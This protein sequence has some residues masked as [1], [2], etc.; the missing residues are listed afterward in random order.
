MAGCQPQ[1]RKF[2]PDIKYPV[3]N[4]TAM[5]SPFVKWDHSISWLVPKWTQKKSFGEFITVNISDPE[6]AYLKG[7]IIDGRNLLP[8]ATYVVREPLF[9]V[10]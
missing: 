5:I 6:W 9:L 8:A 4:D 10:I 7:H 2:Y 1:L 3:S